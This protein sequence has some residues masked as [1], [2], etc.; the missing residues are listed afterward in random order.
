MCRTTFIGHLGINLLPLIDWNEQ[1]I[2]FRPQVC[3]WQEVNAT[4]KKYS[5]SIYKQMCVFTKMSNYSF[6]EDYVHKSWPT[7]MC[8][9]Q[10]QLQSTSED[11]YVFVVGYGTIFSGHK[12]LVF[13]KGRKKNPGGHERYLTLPWLFSSEYENSWAFEL[14]I[15]YAEQWYSSQQAAE[16][17]P[18]TCLNINVSSW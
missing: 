3:K 12:V 13:D 7:K 15:N 4:A 16:Y 8:S 5:N 1:V 10:G 11:S 2:S 14:H 9:P 17:V 6:K 18:K